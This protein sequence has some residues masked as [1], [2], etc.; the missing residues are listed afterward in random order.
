MALTL[1]PWGR[2]GDEEEEEGEEY[3]YTTKD[4]DKVNFN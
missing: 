3:S 1:W 4:G 2:V